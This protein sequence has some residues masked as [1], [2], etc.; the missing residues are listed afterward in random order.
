MSDDL[1]ILRTAYHGLDGELKEI[2]R[3]LAGNSQL[4]L[5]NYAQ[6]ISGRL[7]HLESEAT[8]LLD[9]MRKAIEPNTQ[10][11]GVWQPN[12]EAAW[13]AYGKLKREIIPIL[14]SEL[15]AVIG[16]AFLMREKLDIMGNSPLSFSSLAQTLVDNLAWRSKGGWESVL[17]VSEERIGYLQ[18]EI[19]RLRFPACDIWNLPF[20]AHEYGYVVGERRNLNVFS[21]FRQEVGKQVDPRKHATNPMTQDRQSPPDSLCFLPEVRSFW[22]RYDRE[23]VINEADLQELTKRQVAHLCRLF[24]EAFATLFVGP[25]YVHALLQLRFLPDDSLY[26][27]TPSMPA[28]AQR[29]VFALQ[30]LKWMDGWSDRYYNLGFNLQEITTPFRRE[31]D[32]TQG[33]FPVLWRQTIAASRQ[34]DNYDTIAKTYSPWFKKFE[35]ALRENWLSLIADQQTYHNWLMATTVLEEKIAR[36]NLQIETANPVNEWTVL[37]A[38]WS[39]RADNPASVE[40]IEGNALLLLDPKEQEKVRVPPKAGSGEA[41]SGAT[42]EEQIGVVEKALAVHSAALLLFA[43]MKESGEY[44]VSA[45]ILEVIKDRPAENQAYLVLCGLV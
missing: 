23:R 13:N 34:A 3:W 35:Q 14:A 1:T 25:A 44:K 20:A 42:R 40:R 38:A 22:E 4:P 32:E 36:P 30:T 2:L 31:V 11:S 8:S 28:F 19:I 29:F 18:A 45:T 41:R 37:N 12:V 15:L 24:A 7:S 17:I 9:K 21:E 5:G 26:T 6:R 39:A 10:G 43:K 16:G 33:I 27:P